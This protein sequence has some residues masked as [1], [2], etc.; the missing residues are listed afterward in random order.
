MVKSLYCVNNHFLIKGESI[1]GGSL[2]ITKRRGTLLSILFMIGTRPEAIKML[3][4]FALFKKNNLPVFLCISSQHESI[5][6]E[7]LT[8]FDQTPDFKLSLDTSTKGLNN[9][10]SEIIKESDRLFKDHKFT[11]IFV[12]GDTTTVCAASVAAFNNKISIA[13]V[14]AGLRTYDLENPFPEEGYRNIVSRIATHHYAP[15]ITA[16]ENLIS[17]KINPAN[18]SLVGNTVI[19]ALHLALDKINQNKKLVSDDL[20]SFCEKSHAQNKRLFLLTAHRREAHGE[21]LKNIFL[22]IKDF[23]HQNPH[24]N[25][26]YPAH[27]N[28]AI[29]KVLEETSFISAVNPNQIFFCKALSYADLVYALSNADCVA[30]DSGGIQEEAFAL[31]KPIIC[32]RNTTERAEGVLSGMTTVVG[33]N[34]EKIK[35]T[36]HLILNIPSIKKIS[37]LQAYGDGKS[38]EKILNH[39]KNLIFTDN[40]NAFVDNKEIESERIK[41]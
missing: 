22:S 32:L 13:H 41:K 5:L 29:E 40:S 9:T 26:I 33:Y 16:Y 18:I 4:L 25:C 14:E 10:F 20:M 17:E 21:G 2:K 23:L 39:F 11:W 15:T 7:H 1:V 35:A 36:L 3:P 38:C 8:F 37:Q 28:P 12:Q 19:D 6:Q 31:S 30:T 34:Q 27:P 24:V